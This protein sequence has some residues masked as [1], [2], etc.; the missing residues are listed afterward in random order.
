MV[1]KGL[2]NISMSSATVSCK[3]TMVIRIYKRDVPEAVMADIRDNGLLLRLNES[4]ISIDKDYKYK[5]VKNT[6]DL[7]ILT[8]RDE[9]V[10]GFK[11]KLKSTPFDY[12]T[13]P[14]KVELSSK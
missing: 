5:V 13:I 12:F 7:L 9:I 14:C 1:I 6:D 8:V 11:A 2:S 4:P 10:L 3:F